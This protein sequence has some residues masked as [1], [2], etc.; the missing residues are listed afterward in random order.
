MKK[1]TEIAELKAEMKQLRQQ[2][3]WLLEQLKIV[4]RQRF[5]SRSEKY[6]GLTGGQISLFESGDIAGKEEAATEEYKEIGPY[7]QRVPPLRPVLD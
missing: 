4:R 2:N 7:Y 5:G 1:E 3:Q 6:N